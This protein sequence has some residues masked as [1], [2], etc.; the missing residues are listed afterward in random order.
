ML[1]A[2]QRGVMNKSEMRVERT[3]LQ[4]ILEGFKLDLVLS[5]ASQQG[6]LDRV[7]AEDRIKQ[8]IS[9]IGYMDAKIAWLVA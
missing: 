6:A 2:K 9:R 3:R 1:G 7:F 5:E 8:L 4:V